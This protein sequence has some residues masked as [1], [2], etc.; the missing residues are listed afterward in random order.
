MLIRRIAEIFGIK[1]PPLGG[2]VVG[3]NKGKSDMFGMTSSACDGLRDVNMNINM[4]ANQKV[5]VDEMETWVL[6]VE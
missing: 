2:M 4:N 1:I 3:Q 6:D 5:D